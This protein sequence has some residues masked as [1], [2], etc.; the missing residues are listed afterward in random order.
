MPAKFT[1][2]LTTLLQQD[3]ND[4]ELLKKTL[5]KE[6]EALK[7]RDHT[8]ISD[9][10]KAKTSLVLKIES[11]SKAKFKLLKAVGIDPIKEDASKKLAK[12]EDKNLLIL[13][14]A[15]K[16]LTQECKDSNQV[17]GTVIQRSLQ[18][19]NHI[20][21]IM[22]GQNQKKGLYGAKGTQDNLGGSHRIAKA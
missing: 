12:L 8:E 14:S 3:L 10:T 5:A 4:L 11:R 16:Q 20:M 17:N 21:N 15:V 6:K 22:R 19:T 7:S 9:L 1:E 2:Q 18:R 13:W